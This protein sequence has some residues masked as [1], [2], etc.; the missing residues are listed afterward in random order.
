MDW[1]KIRFAFLSKRVVGP[2]LVYLFYD[3]LSKFTSTRWGGY[4]FDI[5]IVRCINIFCKNKKFTHFKYKWLKADIIWCYYRFGAVPLEYFLMGFRHLSTARRAKFLTVRHKDLVMID[6]VGKGEM[7]DM[8]ENKNL[9]YQKFKQFFKRDVFVFDKECDVNNFIEFCNKHNRF[10]AKPVNG[11]CGRGVEII[12]T[13]DYKSPD[14]VFEY[15]KSKN[16]DYIIEEL[17]IQASQ[18][19]YWNETSVNTVRVPSFINKSGFHILK[20]FFR[21]GR[22]G[23]IVDNAGGGGIFSVV[24]EKTGILLTDACDEMGNFYAEHPDSN[25]KFIGWQIPYWDELLKTVEEIHRTIP[26]YPYVGWDLALTDDRGWVL[27]EGN[28]GQFVSEFADKEGIKDKF[29]AM[30]D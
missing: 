21:M 16:V 29:D 20:P 5:E 10:I 11:Q 12:N 15:I 13:S 26:Y 17:I 14:E 27:I 30:F 1:T 4:W 7:W 24:D 18:M 19:S 23:A 9:F 8:L 22:K 2:I 25:H 6:K 28:W 3:K